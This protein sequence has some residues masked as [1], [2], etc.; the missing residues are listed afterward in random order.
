MYHDRETDGT[1]QLGQMSLDLFFVAHQANGPSGWRLGGF[2]FPVAFIVHVLFTCGGIRM[3]GWDPP[4]AIERFYPV[5]P[6][7]I[8]RV[9]LDRGLVGR[10]GV[11]DFS[12]CRGP[13]LVHTKQPCPD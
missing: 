9:Q 8:S 7:G 4:V 13:A 5:A 12:A 10:V 1:K 6:A 11:S 3:V 2:P